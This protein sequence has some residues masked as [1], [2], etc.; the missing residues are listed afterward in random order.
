MSGL[1]QSIT[2]VDQDS[3]P[4]YIEYEFKP[5][6]R[7]LLVDS[8]PISKTVS[9]IDQVSEF[10]ANQLGLSLQDFEDL[11]LKTATASNDLLEKK[12]C[13]F[14]H[15]KAQV[16]RRLGG[17]YARFAE[18]L[19]RNEELIEEDNSEDNK[20]AAIIPFKRKSILVEA[21]L[22]GE[23]NKTVASIPLNRK[24]KLIQAILE[25]FVDGVLIIT[26]NRKLL[27]ANEFGRQ[28]CS[29]ISQGKS[30]INSIPEPI[31]RICQALIDSRE[32]FDDPKVI[33][34]SELQVN[35]SVK[36][37]VRVRWLTLEVSQEPY[38]LV[39]IEDQNQS[40]QNS[41]S[42]DALKYGLTPR[43][44]E[45][46][47]L[48]KANFTYREIAQQLFITLNTVKKHMKNIYAKQKTR[49]QVEEFI[50]PQKPVKGTRVKVAI[51]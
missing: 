20:T 44:E 15:L 10:V 37:R 16:L 30:E 43:E 32:W 50:K 12:I 24:P 39:T 19:I 42:T 21:I 17:E 27:H 40:Y 28:I 41:T 8:V 3:N 4:D 48:R 5:G 11:L 51:D 26:I 34:E 49:I 31:W 45:I 7:E 2:P 29:Q 9:V 33:M 6:V 38:L 13:T 25:G 1:L 47:S 18:E 14:A 46:W 23:E 36:F 22:E 35:Q